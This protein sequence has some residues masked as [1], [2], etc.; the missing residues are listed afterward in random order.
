MMRKAKAAAALA[1]LAAC[2]GEQPPASR[3][4]SPVTAATPLVADAE[5]ARARAAAL[6]RQ[7][8]AATLSGERATLA[9]AALAARV[10]E[11]EA[12]LAAAQAELSRVRARQ[13]ALDQE[14]ARARAPVAQ[15][16]AGLQTQARRPALL[17]LLQPG[18]LEDAVRLRLVLASIDAQV[19]RKAAATQAAVVRAQALA[20]RAAERAERTNAIASTLQARRDELATLAAAERLKA[21]RAAGAASAEAVRALALA[22]QRG[23]V[24]VLMRDT[25]RGRTNAP[26]AAPA[27]RTAAAARATYRLPVAGTLE[28]AEADPAMLTILARG[29]ALVVAP[30]AGNIAFAGP[31]RGFGEIVL[32]EHGGGRVSLVTGLART[33]VARGQPVVAGSPLGQAPAT[34]PRIGLELREN[35]RRIDPLG[36][37][38]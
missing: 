35:G 22:R 37:I 2:S 27:G 18:T 5:R 25:E 10:Q 15:L 1:V 6:D 7:A 14:L 33:A 26:A 34:A 19:T 31:F 16:I 32:I 3:D 30:G 13:R 12:E 24:G 17:A 36:E 11:T 29:G 38:R 23:D 21:Q 9:A 28:R 8:R 4:Q 20:I